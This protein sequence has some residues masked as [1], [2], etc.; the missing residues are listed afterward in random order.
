MSKEKGRKSVS[1]KDET[2]PKNTAKCATCGHRNVA[3]RTRETFL[4]RMCD[5]PNCCQCVNGE[6]IC[7]GC[8]SGGSCQ[9]LTA[10]DIQRINESRAGFK[11]YCTKCGLRV[12]RGTYCVTCQIRTGRDED[13][14]KI[15]EK[16]SRSN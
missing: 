16:I 8:L 4:C 5:K 14:K 15:C 13:G 3:P 2:E 1:F 12:R 9:E 11:R 10:K 6:R 7:C